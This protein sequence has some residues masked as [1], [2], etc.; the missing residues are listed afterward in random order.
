MLTVIPNEAVLGATILGADLSVPMADTDFATV[1]HAL[2]R[3]GVLRFPD[4]TLSDENLRDFSVRFG[5]VQGSIS[6]DYDPRGGV[7][8]VS[9]LSNIR[10]QGQPIGLPD[11]GQDWHTDMSYRDMRGFVNLLYGVQI[12]RRDGRALGGTEFSSMH[13]VYRALPEEVK[14]RLE[15]AT[16][17]HDYNKL[18]EHM[19]CNKGSTRGPLTAEQ[20]AQRPPVSHPVIMIHPLSGT[21]VLYCNPGYAEKIDGWPAGESDAMVEYLFAFQLRPQFRHTHIWTEGDLLLWDHLGTI[22]QAV[23]DYAPDE[24]RLIR[25]CQ[26]LATEV[27]TPAF[28][29]RMG[30]ASGAA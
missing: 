19:R 9:V 27:F 5:R 4:Q 20:R 21:K 6:H 12:P 22:H 30:L 28:Q 11:A 23:A 29:A 16:A 1:L 14:A 15:G 26:V 2:G 25:R 17:T 18:W 3:Y 10:R 24:P 7:P 8:E 13:A